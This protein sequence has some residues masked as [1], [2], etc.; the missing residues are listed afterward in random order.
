MG[1]ITKL[2]GSCPTWRFELAGKVIYAT[3][4]TM[5]QRGPCHGLTN[6]MNVEV[7]GRLMS[8]G[9]IRADRIRREDN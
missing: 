6:D 3:A 2:T 8:D 9:T 7:R 4:D 1:K 5:F